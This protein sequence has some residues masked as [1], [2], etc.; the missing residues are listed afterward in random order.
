MGHIR[1]Y[2]SMKRLIKNTYK[3]MQQYYITFR[4]LVWLK[5]KGITRKIN[6]IVLHGNDAKDREHPL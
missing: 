2:I 3:W 4:F 6:F 5:E 1:G